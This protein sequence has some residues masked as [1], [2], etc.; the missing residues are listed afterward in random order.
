M[1]AVR[2]GEG[3]RPQSTSLLGYH[4]AAGFDWA[5]LM[6]QEMMESRSALVRGGSRR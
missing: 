5:A 1:V 3:V 4:G 6:S 2:V